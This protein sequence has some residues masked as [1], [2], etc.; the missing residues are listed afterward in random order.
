MKINPLIGLLLIICSI[1]LS[2]NE[3]E[4]YF[5]GYVDEINGK[6]FGYHS[7]FPNVNT[8]LLLRGRADYEA[9]EWKTEIVP[10]NYKEKFVTFIWVF[11]MDVVSDPVEFHLSVNNEQ[12][13]TYNNSRTSD[14]G[15]MNIKGKDGAELSFNVTMLDKYEDQMGFAILKLPIDAVKLGKPAVIKIESEAEDNNAWFM[16]FKTEVKETT[17]IYQNKVVAKKGDELFHSIS[18]D[19]VHIDED[20]DVTINIGGTE[21]KSILKAG[22]NKLEI[23]LPKVKD[24]TKHF[25]EIRISDKEAVKKE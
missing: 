3:R 12:W 13:F 21:T 25:A 7:P 15:I 16:T 22:Y 24:T 18:V 9:I 4:S 6:R 10:K 2:Q 23:Y 19:F 14:L 11:G 20:A 1:G 5:Q 17:D 8:S